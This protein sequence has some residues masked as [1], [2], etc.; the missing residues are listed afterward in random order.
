MIEANT[1]LTAA[2]L[3]SAAWAK[4]SK[5]IEARLDLYRRQNDGDLNPTETASLRGKIREAKYILSL[6]KEQE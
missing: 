6:G 1:I 3:Q 4:L 5:H 2:D